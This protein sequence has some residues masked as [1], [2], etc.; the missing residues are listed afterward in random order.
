LG[1]RSGLE[2]RA[3]KREEGRGVQRRVGG[4]KRWKGEEKEEKNAEKR[5][6][7]EAGICGNVRCTC[8][9]VSDGSNHTTQLRHP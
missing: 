8:L 2:R 6:R 9:V 7:D 3:W 4:K 1:R 5:E